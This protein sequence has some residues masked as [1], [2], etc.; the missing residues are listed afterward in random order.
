MKRKS[1][2]EWKKIFI[3]CTK[4]PFSIS[5]S[6]CSQKQYFPPP[7]PTKSAFQIW[8]FY[9]LFL[10]ESAPNITSWPMRILHIPFSNSL[11]HEIPQV[12]FTVDKSTDWKLAVNSS[13]FCKMIKQMKKH[14]KINVPR[15]ETTM[16]VT[17]LLESLEEMKKRE[18]ITLTR[19]YFWE[20]NKGTPCFKISRVEQSPLCYFHLGPALFLMICNKK[21][22]HF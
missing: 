4:F 5:M 19:H 22:N 3:F 17:P 15:E 14:F 11:C 1:T 7:K 6:G 20:Q 16:H 18:R 13:T 12:F 8:D 21:K 2:K 10:G 9:F